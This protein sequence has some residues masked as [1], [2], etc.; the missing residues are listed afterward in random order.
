MPEM[1]DWIFFAIVVIPAALLVW[2]WHRSRKDSSGSAMGDGAGIYRQ[3]LD[4]NKS[5]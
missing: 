2:D 5:W 3:P 1:F 4:G